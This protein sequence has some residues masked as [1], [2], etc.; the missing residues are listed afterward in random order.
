[1]NDLLYTAPANTVTSGKREL[2]YLARSI[3][4]PYLSYLLRGQSV[5]TALLARHVLT[6]VS[7]RPEKQMI[8]SNARRVIAFMENFQSL[9][10]RA[11]MQRPRQ[12]VGPNAFFRIPSGLQCPVTPLV[13]VIPKPAPIGLTNLRPKSLI[14]RRPLTSGAT[15]GGS[16]CATTT[17]LTPVFYSVHHAPG[18]FTDR[19]TTN[20][21]YALDILCCTIS[22][23][24]GVNLL[25]L[26]L[27]LVRLV[28]LRQQRCGPFLLYTNVGLAGVTK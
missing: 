5:I 15:N 2:A 20:G 7:L 10:N 14:Y 25:R 22:S 21:A 13:P 24:Q 11:V 6:V 18:V 3:G 19:L 27:A 8:G 12:D 17:D 16:A 26:G 4:R 23:S 9:R 28:S 1:M